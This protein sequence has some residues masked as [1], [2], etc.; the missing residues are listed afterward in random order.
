MRLQPLLCSLG[1]FAGWVCLCGE[2][3]EWTLKHQQVPHSRH[4]QPNLG[5]APRPR[6][7]DPNRRNKWAQVSCLIQREKV[8]QTVW[9]HTHI[10]LQNMPDCLCWMCVCKPSLPVSAIF[11]IVSPGFTYKSNYCT[12]VWFCELQ[13]SQTS[14]SAILC[15]PVLL[16]VT[17]LHVSETKCERQID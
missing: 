4:E 9:N 13:P 11:A 3:N 6:W 7:N 1:R 17:I 15:K 5:R 16:S 10:Q 14:T 8:E 2:T 12:F